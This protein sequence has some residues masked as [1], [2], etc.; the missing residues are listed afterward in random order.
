MDT[1]PLEQE[2]PAMGKHHS[3][4]APE[5]RAQMV[6]LVGPY[7]GATHLPRRVCELA[8]RSVASLYSACLWSVLLATMECAGEVLICT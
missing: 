5:F 7:M 6:E 8:V 2:V 3:P 1:Y 4:D